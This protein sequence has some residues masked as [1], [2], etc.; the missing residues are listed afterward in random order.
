VRPAPPP[1][2]SLG[3]GLTAGRI[4]L[5]L[6][7]ALPG[8]VRL[9]ILLLE[10]YARST[11]DIVGALAP[12]LAARVLRYLSV[13]ELLAVEPVRAPLLRVPRAC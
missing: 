4:A 3:T 1:S 9:Q 6:D 5:I 8:D 12:A 7:G 2:S 11:R 10:K 13:R